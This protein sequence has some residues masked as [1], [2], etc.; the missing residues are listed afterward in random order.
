MLRAGQSF[1]FEQADIRLGRPPIRQKRMTN[2]Q[3][4]ARKRVQK[5]EERLEHVAILDFETDPFDNIAQDI[6]HPFAAC[7]YSDNF[8]PIVIWEENFDLFIEKVLS[9]IENLP[10]AYTIYAHNGGKF[11]YMFFV[12]KLRGHVMFKGRGLMLAQIGNHQLRDSF[13][14]IPERLAN[15]QKDTFDYSKLKRNVRKNFKAEIIKYM[16]SDCIYLHEIVID[17]LQRFGFKISI[18]QAAMADIKSKY[19]AIRNLGEIS[20]AFIRPYF[21]GGRVDCLAGAGYFKGDFKLYDVNSMYPHV[22]ANCNHPIGSEFL[23]RQ[24]MPNA[25]TIFVRLKC[26]N[27]GA[28]VNRSQNNETT[29]ETREGEFLTTIWEYNVAMKYG[30]IRRVRVIDC[31][32]WQPS[33]RTNFAEFVKPYY[34]KRQQTKAALKKAVEG[35]T[36]YN[37]LKKDDIFL[38]LLLNNGYGKFA[39]NPRRYKETYITEA[40][41]RPPKEVEEN[42]DFG[43]LPVYESERFAIWERPTTNLRFK[44]VA[45]AAS[46]TGAAR[47]VLL[48][49]IQNA[50]NP[51][52][53]DT[54]SLICEQLRN[55]K[56]DAT[57]LG[58]WDLE[59]EFSDVIIA[60]KKLYACKYKNPKKQQ[61]K[62]R[63]KGVTGVTWQDMLDL[64]KGQMVSI[65]A[66]AP[67]ISRTGQQIYITRN[68]RATGKQPIN[69]YGLRN[70]A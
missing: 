27:F 10:G 28:L 60:G 26:V 63:S 32:D 55:H 54:D 7:L 2:Q 44:N 50:A 29:A 49:A 16:I 3:Q 31:L 30:L 35:S 23:C 19:P 12:H 9:A 46:I 4:K 48:E 41:E 69:R 34:D 18:G 40:G 13:H 38:K 61:Y 68:I 59:D 67:T 20:D 24:G 8:E 51:I 14:I 21:F 65:P 43:I 6:I 45:T 5:K 70:Y 15:W 52:Y 62:I 11:D 1:S 37:E 58:A 22:M 33:Q 36:A 66:K 64:L 42:G 17:F 47:A 53:C 39:Q 25:N 57:E 56:L